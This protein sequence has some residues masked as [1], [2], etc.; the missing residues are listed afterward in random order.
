[1]C[2]VG[3]C[4]LCDVGLCSLF[5]NASLKPSASLKPTSRQ[6]KNRASLK[7]VDLIYLLRCNTCKKQNGTRA[8]KPI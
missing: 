1:M 5:C 3:L 2:D 4:S 8:N 7:P 6:T